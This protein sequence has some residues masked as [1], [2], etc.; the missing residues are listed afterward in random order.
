M[1][2]FYKY[3]WF[4]W[5]SFIYIFRAEL[6]LFLVRFSFL[7]AG[8]SFWPK[9]SRMATYLPVSLLV[10]VPLIRKKWVVTKPF[11]VWPKLHS[12]EAERNELKSSDVA[13]LVATEHVPSKYSFLESCF[14]HKSLQFAGASWVNSMTL[15]V[16]I[17][18]TALFP[19]KVNF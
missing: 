13:R 5:A 8:S 1:I 2:A 14:T 9:P 10:A 6:G 12:I 3:T 17:Y 18:I 7:L 15:S 4:H 16:S 11:R 19:G